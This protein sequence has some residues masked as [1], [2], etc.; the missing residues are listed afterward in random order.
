MTDL[1]PARQRSLLAA[2]PFL[3]VFLGALGL[4][5]FAADPLGAVGALGGLR[6]RLAGASVLSFAADDGTRLSARELG[7]R[8]ADVPVVLLHGLG[9]EG[10]YW[11]E[12]AVALRRAGRTVILPDAP[13]S[14]GS[15][16]PRD[17][18][19]GWGIPNRVAAVDALVRAL[20]LARV[21]LVGHSLGGWT[22]GAF[23]L[24][25]PRS[26][27]RLVLVDAAGFTLPSPSA[28]EALKRSLSPGDRAGAVALYDLLFLRKPIPPFGFLVD[29]L[30][31]NYRKDNVVKTLDALREPDGLLG[32]E[33]ALPAGTVFVWGEADAICPADDGRA[34]S[35]KVAGG[36]FHL[37]PGVGHDTPLEAPA[38]FHELLVRVLAE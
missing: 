1:R 25:Q 20:G 21:D 31:R 29:G 13:G 11:T 15:D 24:A 28:Q 9:A 14:G 36:S 23:A 19:A 37:F 16:R 32:R 38:A 34:A 6:L 5:A 10:H 4:G 22:A 8:S 7:P 35:R 2:L 17:D 18:A 12:T 30:A 3:L 27:R 26:V 33:A